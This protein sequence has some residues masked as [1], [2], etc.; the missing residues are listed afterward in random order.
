M[1]SWAQF[2]Q[3]MKYFFPDRW[4]ATAVDKDG[5]MIE[6]HFGIC[7]NCTEEEPTVVEPE[8]TNC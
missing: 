1:S 2:I 5:K 6:G 4:C 8:G 3:S 7:D